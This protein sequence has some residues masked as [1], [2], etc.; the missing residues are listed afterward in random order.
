MNKITASKKPTEIYVSP[1]VD[2]VIVESNRSILIGSGGSDED[3]GES[4]AA[5]NSGE[6]IDY[7]DFS[8]KLYK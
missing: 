2:F 4:G 7:H 1:S 3:Y 5:G 6:E 8:N